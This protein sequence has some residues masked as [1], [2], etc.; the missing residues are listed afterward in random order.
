MPDPANIRMIGILMPS[1]MFREKFSDIRK[2]TPSKKIIEPRKTDR[3]F[4]CI[5]SL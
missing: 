1:P 4:C 2:Y 5:D 3:P